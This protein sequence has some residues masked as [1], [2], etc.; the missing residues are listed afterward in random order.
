MNRTEPSQNAKLHPPA[1][2]LWKSST[3]AF[4][5]FGTSIHGSSGDGPVCP[6]IRTLDASQSCTGQVGLLQARPDGIIPAHVALAAFCDRSPT[7]RV[8]LVPS[9]M[10]LMPILLLR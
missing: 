3:P 7:M 9:V 2:R 6:R 10:S 5:L 1:C 8:V 4:L